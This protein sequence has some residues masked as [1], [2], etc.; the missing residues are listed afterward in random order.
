MNAFRNLLI[1][2]SMMSFISCGQSGS[3]PL[4]EPPMAERIAHY[5]V[6]HGDTRTDYY[7]WMNNP[8][9]PEVI[10]YLEAENAY[11]EQIMAHTAKLQETLFQEMRGRIR[12]DD[13]S[14][15]VL[16]NGYY[17]YVR[18]ETGA[19]YPIY[20]RRKGSMDAQEEIILNVNELAAGHAYYR[21]G[22]YDISLDNKK[23][24]F[25]VDTIGRRQYTLKIKDLASGEIT[26]TG[27][28][29]AGGDVV[30][31]ADNLTLFFTSI[32]PSTLR[33]EKINRFRTDGNGMP[34][35]VYYEE[36][37]TF[38]YIGVSRSRDNRY[39]MITSNATLSN[40]I[41]ILEAS[42]PAGAFRVFQPRTRDLLY[43]VFPFKDSFFV[44]TNHN[45]QNFRLMQTPASA[46]RISNWKE[47]I[48]HRSDVL[49]ESASV[50]ND[51][52]VLQERSR[53][54]RQM[55]IIRHSDQTEHYL[56]FEEEAYTAA[57]GSNPE[58]DTE[59]LRFTYTSLTTPISQF[60]YNM[61]SREKVL[62]KQQEVLGGFDSNN[63]E[64]KR[65]W[66]TARDG[67]EVPLTI[68]YK[69]GI[70]QDGGNPLLLYSYGSYGS[71]SDPR[72]NSNV[73]SL[74]DRGFVYAIAH[75]RGGQDLGRQWYED[76]KLLKKINTFND[77]I[78]C[79]VYLIE[80]GYTSA[81]K[82]FAMGGSAGGL[83]M[84]AVVNMR[85]DL[86][87]GV[88][89]AVPFVDVVTTMLDESIPLTTAEYD[90]WGNPN[91]REYYD[92]MLSYS[93]YDNITAQAYPNLYIT[94]GLYDSQVQYW[95][96]TKWTARL[97]YYHTGDALI[98]LDTNMEAGHGGASGR[99]SRLRE[100]ARQYAFLIDLT[101]P[102]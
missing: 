25:T 41:H 49:L 88:I 68:V 63:Y 94:S 89:A 81:E 46:T 16:S 80:E 24:A 62:V 47:R 3:G 98:L 27:I 21:V 74:L 67:V 31:A 64:T 87:K 55:R 101:G 82:L 65:L 9:N 78:D 59:W 97:R 14:A 42:N 26:A 2:F 33:Y 43:R 18:Y 40:E 54:L 28:R 4:A 53:G 5:L 86:Y 11:R 57:L 72:F 92:Y 75:I 15:P 85:P 90:E 23:M 50:F 83:L 84:G 38:Y 17:Y 13:S 56:A 19:E 36:D 7:Y 29:N 39:L 91:I 96:P 12:E 93:P 99:F 95:E 20:C 45:A 60:D 69:K 70:R 77:F 6:M 51:Y 79:S 30:W 34:E 44:L 35:T 48:P 58:M 8:E 61:A 102:R 1:A 71:S 37:E 22:D 76:G 32:D 73:L 52:L 66:V 10:A 100:I